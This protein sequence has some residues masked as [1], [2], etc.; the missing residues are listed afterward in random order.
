MYK[1][2]YFKKVILANQTQI[3]EITLIGCPFQTE[4]LNTKVRA[5]SVL[6]VKA[7]DHEKKIFLKKK[8]TQMCMP[9]N[10]KVRPSANSITCISI[11]ILC[12]AL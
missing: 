5:A 4:A 11:I 1:S 3:N 12:K 8:E 7:G 9:G 10:F 6:T 2:R